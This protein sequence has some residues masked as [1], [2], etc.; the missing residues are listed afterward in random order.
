MNEKNISGNVF[1][2]EDKFEDLGHY[3]IVRNPIT[4]QAQGISL[5]NVEPDDLRALAD[6]IENIKKGN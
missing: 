2:I 3:F 4:K 1:A 5:K 6:F